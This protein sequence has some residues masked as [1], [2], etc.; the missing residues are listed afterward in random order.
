MKKTTIRPVQARVFTASLKP[1]WSIN[2]INEFLELNKGVFEAYAIN[3]DK[4][5]D[6]NGE[7]VEAHTHI[8]LIYETPRRVSTIAKVLGDVGANFVEIVNN[9]TTFLRYLTH[10]NDLKKFQYDNA[11]V[12]SNSVP[13][14]EVVKGSLLTDR[15]IIEAVSRGDEFSLIGSVSMTK[16]RLAQSLVHNRALA[17]AN[18]TIAN[19]RETNFELLASVNNM[20]ARIET[21]DNNFGYLVSALTNAGV[22]LSDSMKTLT[23]KVSNEIRLAR[24]GIKKR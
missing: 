15:E 5:I 10:K 12:M 21:I 7:L 1:V 3:H 2:K 13:Y 16:I 9:K 19:L 24:M 17:N 18:S 22:Q 14:D 4:D 11:E 20:L 6:E 8:L 23:D